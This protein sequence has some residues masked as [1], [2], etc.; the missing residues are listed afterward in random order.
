MYNKKFLKKKELDFSFGLTTLG[1]YRAKYTYAKRN[2]RS[3]LKNN[4]YWYTWFIEFRDFLKKCWKFA[5]FNNG[6]VFV[7]GPT[8]SGKSTTLAALIDRINTS[9]SQHI[10]TIEDPIEYLHRHKK[11]VVEQREIKT[12]TELFSS[13]LKY[14]L[15][16]DPDVIL[17]GE[18]RDLETIESALTAAETGHLVFANT[19]YKWCGS[20]NR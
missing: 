20:N 17:I 12:D 9:T 14:A 4:N 3:S 8:G 1:R 19:T 15:R 7:T 13:A 10:I 18:M 2:R 11:S 16:Q 6:L 5:D